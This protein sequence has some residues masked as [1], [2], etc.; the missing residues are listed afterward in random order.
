ASTSTRVPAPVSTTT[1]VPAPVSTTTRVSAPVSTTTRVPAPVSTT[2]VATTTQLSLEPGGVGLI[3]LFG[4]RVLP[5]SSE[6]VDRLMAEV[7]VFAGR[8]YTNAVRIPVSRAVRNLSDY[9]QRAWCLF[10]ARLYETRFVARCFAACFAMALPRFVG[11]LC[12]I[13]AWDS[14]SRSLLPL[15]GDRLRSFWVS[16]DG[17]ILKAVMGLF[18]AKWNAYTEDLFVPLSRL[19]GRDFVNACAGD[20]SLSASKFAS[21]AGVMRTQAMPHGNR[22]YL[23]GFEVLPEVREMVNVLIREVGELAR[24]IFSS[25]VRVLVLDTISR[26]SASEQC[27]WLISNMMLYR[28]SLVSKCFDRYFE[29]LYPDFTRSLF[30]VRVGAGYAS[31]SSLLSLTGDLLENFW[32]SLGRTIEEII[33]EIFVSEWSKLI[34]QSFVPLESSSTVLCG[35]DFVNA[36]AR[37]GVPALAASGSGVIM[38]V[39]KPRTQAVSRAGAAGSGSV[40]ADVSEVQLRRPQL[41]TVGNSPVTTSAPS[42]T[43]SVV[44]EGSAMVAGSSGRVDYSLGLKKSLMIRGSIGGSSSSGVPSSSGLPSSGMPSSSGVSSSSGMPSSSVLSSSSV[45]GGSLSSAPGSVSSV[46]T[47]TTTA[48]YTYYGDDDIGVRLAALMNRDLPSSLPAS[49]STPAEGG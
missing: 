9:E 26:L 43:T 2:T 5:E 40:T 47:T 17:A 3:D 37:V 35:G 36:H 20:S 10:N 22:A 1:R 21:T 46:A 42:V 19:C 34:T 41:S 15:M 44:V 8:V 48:T 18:M 13:R 23:F 16:L 28:T 12:S 39:I 31:G 27:A 45:A 38:K 30:R 7:L 4:L 6:V 24:S 25:M 14:S 49:E 32:S 29:E 33:K 11:P